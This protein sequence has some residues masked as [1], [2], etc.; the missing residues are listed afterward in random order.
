MAEQTLT[1]VMDAPLAEAPSSRGHAAK[2][3]AILDTAMR[4]FARDGF[5]GAS[6]DS[7]AAEAGVSR[8]TVYNHV[9][10]KEN[11]FALVVEDATVRQNAGLFATLA[12]FPDRPLD[13]EAELIAFARRLAGDCLCSCRSA[14]LQR[15][16]ENEGQ[17]Y[18]ELFKAWK[19]RGPGRLDAAISARLSRLAQS[20]LLDVDDPDLASRQFVA[21]VT[22]DLESSNHL[23]EDP[24]PAEVEAA[25]TAGVKTFLRAYRPR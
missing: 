13:L 11:L 9:R 16:V 22:M 2:R 8:Q 20:G 1:E 24:T 18:P 12:T 7:I 10:D 19:E 4:V 5:A 17:R 14:E 25:A 3:A 15:L 23:G 6:I 21:L